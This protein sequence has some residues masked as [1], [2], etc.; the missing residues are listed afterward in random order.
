MYDNLLGPPAFC[1]TVRRTATT[2]AA[3][4][5]R[6]DERG[7]QIIADCPPDVLRRAMHY[8]YTK[9]TRSSFEIEHEQPTS[10]SVERFVSLLHAAEHDDYVDKGKLIEL[11]N[12]IVDPRFR[13][14]DYRHSQN[15]V[16][17]TVRPGYEKVHYI[18]PKPADVQLLMDGW[19]ACHRL[20]GSQQYTPSSMRR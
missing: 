18:P 11:Q 9:E 14:S 19:A 3:E 16:G 20:M 12:Q 5:E 15:Y 13:E 17:Q 7:R 2:R 4:A 1:P 10:D 8:L 6:L